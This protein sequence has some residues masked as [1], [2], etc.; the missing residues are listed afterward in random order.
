MFSFGAFHWLWA[1]QNKLVGPL[2]KDR[3]VVTHLVVIIWLVGT[4]DS[5]SLGTTITGCIGS[6][7]LML[8]FTAV[9][10]KCLKYSPHIIA[11]KQKKS[12]L[13]AR[14]FVLYLGSNALI[15]AATIGAIIVEN[16]R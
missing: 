11:S 16:E 2:W 8:Q 12:V 3:G 9:L 14:I 4:I 5:A 1:V 15:W 10:L 13:W 6:G 7:L